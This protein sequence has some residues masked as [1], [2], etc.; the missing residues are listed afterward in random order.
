MLVKLFST[1]YI[2]LTK[3][4]GLQ[5]TATQLDDDYINLIVVLSKHYVRFK[6]SSF[7]NQPN[8]KKETMLFFKNP[9]RKQARVEDGIVAKIG[10]ITHLKLVY[11]ILTLF[12]SIFSFSQNIL[13]GKIEFENQSVAGVE[14]SFDEGKS[15]V[16]SDEEGNFQVN[17]NQD[18]LKLEFNHV[19]YQKFDKLVYCRENCKLYFE[20]Q[21]KLNTK[22]LD[23]VV[24]TGTLK[25]VSKKD[26]SIPVEV[27]SSKVFLKNPTPSLFESVGMING[28]QPQMNCNVCN[29]GDIHINGLEGPYTLILIDG[30]PIVSSLSTV[31]GLSGIPNSMVDRIE[32]VKGPAAALFGSEA[33][34]GIINVITKNPKKAKKMSFDIFA[35][36]WQEYSLDASTKFNLGKTSSLLGINYFNY[37]NRID[38]N[39]DNFTDLTLQNRISIFNKWNF[40]RRNNRLASLAARFVYEDRAGGEMQ[41]TKAFR[42]TDIFYGESIYTNRWELIGMYQLPLKEKIMSQFSYNWHN[43]DSFYGTTSY[44]A[45]QQVFFGQVFWDKVIA[46]KHSLLFGLST[47]YTFYDD[48]TV[49]TSTKEGIN[50]PEKTFLP[51]FFVQDEWNL[52]D[53]NK[54]L[55][56]YR[57]DY[58]KVHGN[59]HSPRIAYKLQAGKFH[60]LRGSFGTGFRVVNLF[61]ED[62]AALTGSREVEVVENLQPEKSIN[63]TLNYVTKIPLENTIV[64]FDVTAFYT[65]FSNKIIGDFDADPNKIIYRNLNGFGISKGISLNTGIH[66]S[67]P[68]KVNFGISYMDVFVEQDG[69]KSQQIHAPKWSGTYLISYL[70]PKSWTLDLTGRFSGSMRL[71]IQENDF[72]SEYSP[73]FTIANLQVTKKIKSKYEVYAG[74]KNILNFIPNN[75]IM[76]PF[77]PFDKNVDDAINNPRG[78]TFDA[79]YNYSSMQGIRTFAGMRMSF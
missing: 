72:R 78:Y 43:Q 27:I 29:T 63:T 50:T 5:H 30:M 11:I 35:T 28:V 61:T 16:F 64:D 23:E 41:F 14:I 56:G 17:S 42:G 44:Q 66:F 25:E 9:F 34:G 46:E 75:P 21:K 65:R 2:Q 77:D 12:F 76:R 51:G 33:M 55:V 57:Y 26:S 59:I 62:H 45:N 49:G 60:T 3:I 18:T 58:H 10:G 52:N 37:T 20:F 8:V 1:L 68:L 7:F 53:K 74:V 32:V 54:L 15:V 73:F 19:D 6:R 40:E 67:F 24:V 47:R 13:N 70:F 48:N 4:I 79:E 22:V 69:I 36:S 31:Y 71:P 38:N 39:Q